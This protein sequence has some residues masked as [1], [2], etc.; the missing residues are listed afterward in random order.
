V[1]P[2][3][4]LPA[5]RSHRELPIFCKF[6]GNKLEAWT[7]SSWR[8]SKIKLKRFIALDNLFFIGAAI[9]AGEGT[10]H[11]KGY[12]NDRIS[13]GNSE[14]A[15]I[16][17]FVSWL[18]S[19]LLEFNYNCQIEYNG[20]SCDKL[21]LV[22]SW[23]ENLDFEINPNIRIN[24][25]KN[26]GSE[27]LVNNGVFQVIVRN[28]LLRT[29]IINLLKISKE[30]ALRDKEWAIAYLRGLLA[31]E[32]SVPKDKLSQIGIGAT[33][34]EERA[35][36]QNLLKYLEL[37]H[38][39][40]KNQLSVHGWNSY[41]NLFLYDAFKIPQVN[42]INKKDRFLKGLKIHQRTER[43]LRLYPFMGRKFT[44][45]DWQRRYNLALYISAHKYLTSLVKDGF[46]ES[47]IE[48][49]I[50]YYW[51]NPEK[52]WLVKRISNL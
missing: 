34:P 3:K 32:G 41:V 35:F 37:T 5:K 30:L 26:L 36:I 44:A 18:K 7:Y 19:L 2:G 12:N 28:T 10:T 8:N 39:M 9:Y 31:S 4:T 43:L 40:G 25:R 23:Q 24:L 1:L 15:I 21:K 38:S 20:K 16:N 27:L 49:R 11:T 42:S 17:F 51:A 29:F 6:T 48:K 47:S 45:Q 13:L 52:A 22:R 14:P 50:K 33:H 46:V